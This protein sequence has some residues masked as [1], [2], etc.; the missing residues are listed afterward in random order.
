MPSPG[1]A[2]QVAGMSDALGQLADQV[3]RLVVG[4]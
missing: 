2:G 3:A 4:G 1:T